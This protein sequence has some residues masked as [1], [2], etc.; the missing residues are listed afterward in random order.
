MRSLAEERNLTILLTT[1]SPVVMNEFKGYES[2]FFVLEP[3]AT[4]TV[5]TALDQ[6]R[7]EAWLS[8]FALGDLYE[9]GAIGGSPGR[10]LPPASGK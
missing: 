1:H 10:G 9:R 3:S 2:Q 6:V 8:H 4:G 5:P 7:S